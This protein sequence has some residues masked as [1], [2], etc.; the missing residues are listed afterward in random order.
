[1]DQDSIEIFIGAAFSAAYLVAAADGVIDDAEMYAFI[2]AIKARLDIDLEPEVVSGVFQEASE[3]DEDDHLER[4]SGAQAL[5]E[6]L[7]KQILE[8]AIEV[9]AAD[10]EVDISELVCLPAIAAALDLS[11]E[12]GA[13]E[14]LEFEDGYDDI[15]DDAHE[16]EEPASF[17]GDGLADLNSETNPIIAAT[18]NNDVGL[19]RELLASGHSPS[20]IH[21]FGMD[22]VLLASREG[23][24]EIVDVL[25]SAGADP[26]RANPE[27]GTTPLTMAIRK[28]RAE[29]VESLLKHGADPNKQSPYLK[30]GQ[31][32]G[33]GISPLF[34]AG[35]AA[36]HIEETALVSILSA[37]KSAGARD[38][39]VD[40]EGQAASAIDAI[41]GTPGISPS[42]V[43][44][45][46]ECSSPELMNLALV[47]AVAVGSLDHLKALFV[48]GA[49]SGLLELDG[50]QAP[51]IGFFATMSEIDGQ[52]LST[53]ASHS[54][55][56]FVDI[57]LHLASVEGLVEN[58][59]V[60]I[61]AGADVDMTMPEQDYDD[62]VAGD[63]P[64]NAAAARGHTDT[65]K[66]LLS[67]GANPNRFAMPEGQFPLLMA[68]ENGH[69]EV[70]DLLLEAKADPNLVNPT[71]GTHALGGAIMNRY[72]GI[73]GKLLNAGA[74]A[75]IQSAG[76][77]GT[78]IIQAAQD[79]APSNIRSLI[80]H[81]ADI[82]AESSSGN[83]ALM[84][85]AHFGHG[86]A[87]DVLL[88]CG[89]DPNQVSSR[90]GATALVIAAAGNQI[91]VATRL[92]EAGADPNSTASGKPALCLAANNGST[93][94]VELLLQH[95][96]DPNLQDSDGLT[97]LQRA[98]IGGHKDIEELLVR[99][100][101][102]PN[103]QL[104]PARETEVGQR[105]LA[106]LE[107][108]AEK[109]ESKVQKKLAKI[110]KKAK[111]RSFWS[112]LFG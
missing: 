23:H 85:A 66:E 56:E 52:A 18:M 51:L 95:G 86:L 73:V 89:A 31:V 107:R 67:A 39:P 37:L 42:T 104:I 43:T 96:A 61:S 6:D 68:A 111:Q 80:K 72:S 5:P 94:L 26:D 53:V 92:L 81:G 77:S 17:V 93:Q 88:K 27:S 59:K 50:G 24:A 87:T 60:L 70:V 2:D 32:I 28:G 79:G 57:A 82:T 41:T 63:F 19:V 100:G 55:K 16:H 25:L 75:N 62:T 108:K 101:A 10:G 7:R 34:M 12:E 1:M 4:A 13:D 91:K 3:I 48:G 33:E 14:E 9:A 97:A 8:I 71:N 78:P 35:L 98:G 46:A 64:L 21:H 38:N 54:P 84:V 69:E 109:L 22:A 99:N 45:V 65:V 30:N 15:P 40:M 36:G 103:T 47:K 106:K 11:D 102:D 74:D 44:M 58:V 29:V 83:T 110:E 105:Q 90:T 20:D 112:R 76:Y 49:T